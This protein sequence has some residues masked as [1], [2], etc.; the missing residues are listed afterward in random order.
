[1]RLQLE[2]RCD[3]TLQAERIFD[4]VAARRVEALL[5]R[6]S[7]GARFL[8]DLSRVQEIHDFALAVLAHA[9]THS[10]ADVRGRGLRPQRLELLRT[11][12]V[13]TSRLEQAL[14]AS[15]A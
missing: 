9:L 6:A 8:L 11:F 13:E 4:G 7:S 15:A 3:T 14:L 2:V 10:L 1:M 12:G 5:K